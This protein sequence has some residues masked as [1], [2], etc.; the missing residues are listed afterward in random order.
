MKIGICINS[1]KEEKD[2]NN[3]EKMCVESLHRVKAKYSDIIE[4]YNLTFIDETFAKIKNFNNIHCLVKKPTNITD[5]KIPFV[6]EIF[7]NLIT[8]PIDYFIFINNDIFLSDRYIK[9]ILNNPNIDCFP[10]SKLHFMKMD[11]L[12]DLTSEPE[13]LSVHGFDGFGIKTEW[14]SKNKAKF[15]QMLLSRAYWDT[16]FFTKC[17]IYG[18]C[19][20]LNKP[21]AVIFHLDHKSTSMEKDSGND[22]NERMFFQDPDSLGIKWFSYVEKVLKQRPSHNGILWYIPFENEAELERIYFK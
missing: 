6:N 17:M 22:Y 9:A 14:W 16:Y 1:F 13:S 7:N 3:R 8:L 4:L 2:F 15:N 18:K 10:A 19:H 21:P 11:S 5:K 20:V 12:N